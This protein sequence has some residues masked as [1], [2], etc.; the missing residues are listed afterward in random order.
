MNINDI[1]LESDILFYLGGKL[2]NFCELINKIFNT[3]NIEFVGTEFDIN[4]Y[5][6]HKKRKYTRGGRVDIMFSN[7]KMIVPV[8]LKYN[9]SI[10]GY[11]QIRRYI[12]MIKSNTN[13][14]VN[15]ILL[16]K[17]ATKT[18]K[19]FDIDDDILVF[20]LYTGEVW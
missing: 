9:A 13:R 5:F 6:M 15:G 8:E 12:D 7:D 3:T 16:C 11:Y 18:L 2:N 1:R 14:E 10:D 17:Y 19:K 4:K 20:E